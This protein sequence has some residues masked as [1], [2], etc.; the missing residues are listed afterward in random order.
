MRR[1]AFTPDIPL[2]WIEPM[3]KV[4]ALN[5]SLKLEGESSTEALLKLVLAEM[6]E[7]STQ[8]IRVAALNLRPGVR[9]DEGEGDE[10]PSLRKHINACDVLLMGTPIWLGQP[11][12]IAK[13]VLERMDAFL[14]EADDQG[15]TPAY[16]KVAAVVVV[17]NEDGAHHV[18]AELFQALADVGFTVPAGGPAYWVGEAMGATDFKDLKRV[19]EKVEAVVKMLAKNAVHLAELLKSKP[20]P[21]Y[22]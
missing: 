11:S 18:S 17:G 14:G 1:L 16:G 21:G 3:P 2:F 19:P 6:N 10:W 9:S 8:P 22:L 5:C 13:R 15:R 4:L 7:A 12:S 20:Y